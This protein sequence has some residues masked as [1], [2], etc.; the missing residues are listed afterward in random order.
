MTYDDFVKR[1]LLSLDIKF[2]HKNVHPKV[3]DPVDISGESTIRVSKHQS[4]V[5]LEVIVILVVTSRIKREGLQSKM[6][7]NLIHLNVGVSM[8]P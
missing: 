5:E 3:T 1:W 7:L 2:F 8:H 4:K 6:I